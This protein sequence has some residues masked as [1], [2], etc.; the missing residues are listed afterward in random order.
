[1]RLW[2]VFAGRCPGASSTRGKLPSVLI[3]V[4]K[5]WVIEVVCYLFHSLEFE[6]LV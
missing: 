5:S 3:R 2:S 6:E 1:M 4:S